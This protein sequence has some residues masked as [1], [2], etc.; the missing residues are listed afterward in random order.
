MANEFRYGIDQNGVRHPVCDDTRVDWSSYAV[1]GAKNLLRPTLTT[2]TTN[3]VTFTVNEDKTITVNGTATADIYCPVFNREYA[4]ELSQG[5]YLLSGGVAETTNYKFYLQERNAGNTDWGR[6]YYDTTGEGVQY[7]RT[8]DV[9]YAVFI[10]VKSGATL[11]NVKFYPMIT[12]AS[13][14]DRTYAPYVMTNKKLTEEVTSWEDATLGTPSSGTLI[15]TNNNSFCK[16]DEKTIALKLQINN[17]S[18]N[19]TI[20]IGVSSGSANCGLVGFDA[21]DANFS[22]IP[23]KLDGAL[24]TILKAAGVFRLCVSIP[25]I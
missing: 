25:R 8:T 21:N 1:L 22:T 5:S 24:L 20:N 18:A 23:C 12:L 6:A 16:Y 4:P 3:G 19:T 17:C 9:R 15:D 11:N 7:D 13:D 10:W 2:F 14:T